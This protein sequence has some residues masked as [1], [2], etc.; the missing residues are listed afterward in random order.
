MATSKRVMNAA[1]P[2]HR[3]SL[4]VSSSKLMPRESRPFTLRGR[5]TE[6]LRS[7]RGFEGDGV[8]VSCIVRWD[9]A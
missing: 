6:I 9:L 4:E 2:L 8:L 7:A 1:P 3:F 5:R